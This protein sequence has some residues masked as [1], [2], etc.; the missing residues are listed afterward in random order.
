MVK[1]LVS[2]CLSHCCVCMSIYQQTFK[3]PRSWHFPWT[4][5]ETSLPSSEAAQIKLAK[6][7]FFL[8]IAGV[9][10]NLFNIEI[11]LTH[12]CLASGSDQKKH[13]I[14]LVQFIS[15]NKKFIFV[16]ETLFGRYH[17]DLKKNPTR[18]SIISE[19]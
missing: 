5:Q 14:H 12:L 3:C 15:L 2:L 11:Q 9:L 6:S 10:S 13:E 7:E 17:C 18:V 1:D 4:C 16:S 19:T 8:L